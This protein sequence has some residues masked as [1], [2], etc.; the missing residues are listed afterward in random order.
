M[1]RGLIL[2]NNHSMSDDDCAYIGECLE[3]F[4]TEYGLG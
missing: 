4:V 3:A 2:P 1:E